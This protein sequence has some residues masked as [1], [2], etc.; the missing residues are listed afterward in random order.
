MSGDWRPLCTSGCR[1]CRSSPRT[2]TY[3]PEW[4]ADDIAFAD[5]TSLL[6]TPDHYVTRLL[7]AHGVDLGDLGVGRESFDAEDSRRAFRILCEHWSAYRG[8][9]VR[10]WLDAQLADIFGVTVRPSAATADAI[11]D[12]IADRLGRPEYRARALF[13]RFG[14]E[15]LATTDDPCDDLAAHRRLADDPT[16]SARVVPTFRPD[17]YL[18]PLFPTWNS[19]VDR[20]AEASGIETGD[21]DGWLAA[22]A[23]RRAHFIA[24]G[25]V[26][27]D[28]SH[29]DTRTDP[30]EH[31]GG[32]PP[33][34]PGPQ[35]RDHPDRG[36]RPAPPPA[37]PDG[38]DVGRGRAGDDPAP[39][40]PAQPPHRQ[41][42]GVRHRHRRGHPR[43]G[44]VHRCPAAAAGRG[45]HAPE[46][47]AGAVHRGR[48]DVLPRDRAAG[49]LLPERVRGGP[50]VVP[51]RPRGDPA[52][53]RR[54]SPRRRASPRPPASSTT[55]GPSAPSP[56]VT[57]CPVDSTPPSWPG[58]S[59]TTDWTRTRRTRS[60]TTWWTPIRVGRSSCEH[61]S[62]DDPRRPPPPVAGAA[63]HPARRTGAHR[64]PRARQLPP[65]PS[66]LVHRPRRRRRRLGH[67]G[68][69]RAP[70]RRGGCARPSGRPVHPDHPRVRR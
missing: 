11:Y 9:P 28:H 59:P 16:W 47:P 1:A 65:G 61:L 44:G 23:A 55:P 26:S 57:T 41:R 6:I 24:H 35:G 45:G 18:E 58:W 27:A 2:A 52:L 39:G 40:H 30:L 13:E 22:M 4:L 3:R 32:Q 43:A 67:R 5:P 10:F 60:C 70:A 51:G 63:G 8:T 66:G 20:L 15:V 12:Q 68:V 19:D 37:V 29:L 14:I 42:A 46:L 50:V 54:P 53:P 64:A 69:H 56:P 34:R 7:H 33:L 21:Y 62:R 48:D 36:G 31:G 17:R 38:A 25:A 49:R